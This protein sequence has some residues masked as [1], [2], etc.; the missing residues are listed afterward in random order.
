MLGSAGAVLLPQRLMAA[1]LDY[2]Q[3]LSALG[4]ISGM[5]MPAAA[6][7]GRVRQLGLH[8]AAA[9]RHGSAGSR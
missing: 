9:R 1:G 2:E 5:A 3:A 4:V 6:V 7:S 8:G